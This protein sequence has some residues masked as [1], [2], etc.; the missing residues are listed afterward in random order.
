MSATTRWSRADRGRG[1]PGG[2]HRR[3]RLLV[4]GL[5]ALL[6]PAATVAHHV[7][8]AAPPLPPAVTALAPGLAP[9]GG[10][11]MRAF[12]FAVYD[13]WYWAAGHEWTLDA[14][15]AL[16]LVYHRQL[17][18][19]GI[20]ER[21]VQEIARLGVASP[22][23]LARWGEQMRRIFPDVVPGDRL[24]GLSVPPGVVRFFGNGA[25]IG[26]IADP[27]FARAFFGIW[28]DPRTSHA[29]YRARLLGRL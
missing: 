14:P 1:A 29:D 23:E 25:P 24:T 6:L 21:S 9:Q 10:G 16:D 26:E 3:S 17:S 7:R 15:F 19:T 8:V 13:G 20:A 2:G 28:L 4:A 22:V 11:M 5:L 18:G 27:A 12:G